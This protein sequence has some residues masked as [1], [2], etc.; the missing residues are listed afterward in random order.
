VAPLSPAAA[1]LRLR[2]GDT[3]ALTAGPCR[4]EGVVVA[5]D[6]RGIVRFTDP[7]TGRTL[8]ADL[9]H[10]ESVEVPGRHPGSTPDQVPPLQGVSAP[11]GP[12]PGPAALRPIPGCGTAGFP[13]PAPPLPPAAAD[14]RS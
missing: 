2:P 3:F 5:V 14:G 8:M 11:R 1:L 6:L 4:R 9:A 10:W 13:A 7:A 12:A